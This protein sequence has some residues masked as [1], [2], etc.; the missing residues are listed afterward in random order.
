L[1]I[2]VNQ[3]PL[4]GLTY[5]EEVSVSDLD[6]ET[7][8]IKFCAPIKIKADISKI[9][10]AVT[11]HLTI[12][13]RMLSSCSRCLE[14]LEIELNK[15]LDLNYSVTKEDREIDLDPDIREEIVLGYPIKPLCRAD[16]RGLCPKCGKNLNIE[17]CDCKSK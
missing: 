4:E 15:N 8:I 1:K 13:G 11:V 7:E 14:G 10:N 16:C 3:I 5:E 12:N 2:S 17:T 6:L 9:T